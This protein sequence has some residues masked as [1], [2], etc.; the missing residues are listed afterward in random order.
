M[1][2]NLGRMVFAALLMLMPFMGVNAETSVTVAN[3]D[4]LKNALADSTVKEIVLANDIETTEKINITREVTIDGAGHQMKYVGTF[5]GNSDNTMWDGIYVLHVYRTTATIKNI[6]LTG[7]NAA[8]NVNGSKVT[9]EGNIDVS[10]NGF[11]G[12]EMGKGQNVS[13]YPFVDASKAT[14][15]NTTEAKLNPT[16]W[17]DGISVDEIMDNDVDFLLD[18]NAVKGAVYLEDNGQF[19]F[20]L[21]KKNTPSGDGILDVS[22]EE[23]KKEEQETVKPTE[24]KEDNK[25]TKNPNTYDNIMTY[26]IIAALGTIALGFSIKKATSR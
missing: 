14:L 21:E 12:I 19:Q 24:K 11:G 3:Q 17:V 2:K 25:A 5:K 6:T 22:P 1:K 8:L 9:L 15:K 26:V 10:G 13:E 23:E 4:D 16:V 7:G 18:E 20:Y